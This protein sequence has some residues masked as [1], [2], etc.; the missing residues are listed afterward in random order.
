MTKRSSYVVELMHGIHSRSSK[1]VKLV[2][3]LHQE[4]PRVVELEVELYHGYSSSDHRSPGMVKLVMELHHGSPRVVRL[5]VG[6]HQGC[7]IREQKVSRSGEA[8]DEASP[9]K[10]QE[11]EVYDETSLWEFQEM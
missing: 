3:G 11:C 5:E 7:F 1:L 6:L 10:M 9:P 4:D 8:S 2:H